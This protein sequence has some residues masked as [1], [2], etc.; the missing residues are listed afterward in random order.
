MYLVLYGSLRLIVVAVDGDGQGCSI[1][2]KENNG[3]CSNSQTVLF[4][5]MHECIPRVFD[6]ITSSNWSLFLLLFYEL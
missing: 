1:F 5:G 4:I 3:G 6:T 2:F